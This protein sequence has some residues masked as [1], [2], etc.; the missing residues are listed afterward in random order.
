MLPQNGQPIR[1][2]HLCHA[3]T[4]GQGL[5]GAN[6]GSFKKGSMHNRQPPLPL[7]AERVRKNG[8]VYIK[9]GQPNVWREKYRV[10]WEQHHGLIP[11]GQLVRFLDGNYNNVTI[12]NLVL[13]SRQEHAILNH[14]DYENSPADIKETQVLLAKIKARTNNYDHARENKLQPTRKAV[15][16]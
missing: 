12:N 8:H 10:V 14:M 4:K 5:T 2:T 16:Q 1:D 9:T 11:R 6:N 7:G 15:A 3:G 13:V